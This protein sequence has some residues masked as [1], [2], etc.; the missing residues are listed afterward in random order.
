MAGAAD[1]I[2]VELRRFFEPLSLALASPNEFAAFM[3]RFGFSVGGTDVGAAATQ[4]GG[5]RTAINQ[6]GDRCRS[7]IANDFDPTDVA[8][9]AEAALPLFEALRTMPQTLSGLSPA[10]LSPQAFAQSLATFPEELFDALLTDYLVRYA[11]IVLH[12]LALLGVI[13]SEKIPPSGD[14]RS[15]GL[16]YARPVYDWDRIR[17]LF[18]DP[19][20]WAAQAY[21]WGVDFDSNTFILRLARIVEYIGG[22]VQIDDMSDALAEL[23]MPHIVGSTTR[24][25]IALAPIMRMDTFG[26]DGEIDV[27]A[28]GEIGLAIFPVAGDTDATR[29]SDGGIAIGPYADGAVTQSVALSETATMTLTGSLGAVGGVV[30]GFR[31]SGAQVE[32][33]LDATAFAGAFGIDL[34]V[35]PSTGADAIVVLGSADGTRIAIDAFVAAIGGEISNDGFDFF[36]ATGVRN[37]QVVIDPADDGLLGALVTSPIE[38]SAGD[39]LMGWRHGRGIYFEGGSNLA[40]SIPLGIDLGPI[41]IDQMSL[42]LDFAKPSVMVAVSGDLAIGPFYAYAD[43]I[44]VVATIFPDPNGILGNHDLR[45]GFKAPD[46]YALSLDAGPITGGGLIGVG[47]HEYRGALALKFES[48]GFSA[49]ALLNTRLPDGDPGFSLAASIFGEFELPLGY[50]FFLTGLGGVIGVNR[51]VD[52]NA[53]RDVLYDG[54]LDNLLFPADPIANAA[55]ILRDMAAIMPV[56]QGQHLI[57]PVARIVWGKPV[58]IEVTLG[59]IIEIGNHPRLVVV[60]DIST[61]LPTKDAALVSLSMPF[62]GEIDP[63]AGTISFDA[64]LQNSRVLTW[65]ISGDGAIRTGWAPKLNHIASMGG[66]HPGYPRPANLPDLRRLSINFG[67]NNPKV[68]LSAYAAITLAS[69]QFGARADLYAK[70]PKI[71]LV[72]RLAAE[73]NVHFDALIYFNP[74]GFDAKLGGSLQLLIDDDVV[75]GLG[76]DLRLRGPNTYQ[77]NGKVWVSVCGIDVDFHID[78]AWG[79]EQSLP[80]ATADAVAVLRDAIAHSAILEPIAASGRVPGTSLASTD[81]SAIDP[82]GGARFVQRALPLGIAITKVGEAQLGGAKTLDLAAFAGNDTMTLAVANLDFV[83]GHFFELSEAE[84]LRAPDFES[85]KGGFELSPDALAID[86]GK[87]I[88]ETYDYEVILL[89]VTD[90]R[91]APAPVRS[92][93]AVAQSFTDRW[94]RVNNRRTAQPKG[95]FAPPPAVDA[96]VATGATFVRGSDAAA[97][98]ARPHD[99][100]LALLRGSGT[101]FTD[102]LSAGPLAAVEANRAIADYVAAAQM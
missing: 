76:F 53:M 6:F 65:A 21:G 84:R 70:G 98:F 89:D 38:I 8:A 94:M 5:M 55:T 39:I 73:G 30:F 41:G 90:D 26:D 52:V 57:G 58:L 49:F 59:A 50:G 63:A 40:I 33:G 32:T 51:T 99:D 27:E 2:V 93:G 56:A 69:L 46:A 42:A 10:G 71:W 79:D 66:L 67:T 28:S 4:F 77:I 36:A 12:A 15:R 92:H 31:P 95:G 60:G 37:L 72:G 100:A 19:S 97:A 25:I 34:A 20:D 18:D 9:A 23:F 54:R 61:D 83:R 62:F 24:P 85:F 68:T 22:L 16:D 44:G 91:T 74:F 64:T 29:R 75:A 7:V 86:A 1:V 96:I 3:R 47:D 80:P 14:V 102:A 35:T 43:N 13:R 81:A 82:A 101:T 17:V 11:P 45:F 48:F 78:H 87:A 88:V